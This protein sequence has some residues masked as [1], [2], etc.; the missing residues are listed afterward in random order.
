[1]LSDTQRERVLAHLAGCEDCRREAAALRLL[2]RRM[3]ALG[4]AAAGD[5]LT[6]R[7]LA[8]GPA[9]GRGQPARRAHRPPARR[10][11]RYAWSLAA[12]GVATAGLGLTGA[13]FLVGGDR[14]PPGPKVV[15]AVDVFMVQH[16]ITTGQVPAR[17]SGAST[18][19]P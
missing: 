12:A 10:R 18:N 5:A 15:P 11:R 14:P 6:W 9:G 2:K 17:P 8:L 1:E 7:L 3:H 19:V 4:D 16:A 13:V